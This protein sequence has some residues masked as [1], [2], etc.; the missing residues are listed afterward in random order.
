MCKTAW[1]KKKHC[2]QQSAFFATITPSKVRNCGDHLRC[3]ISSR[4]LVTF[5]NIENTRKQEETIWIKYA[6]CSYFDK[7]SYTYS[8]FFK[9]NVRY[10]VW[11]CRDPIS[12]ILRRRGGHI[13][14]Y[15]VGCMQQP[16]GQMWNV[17]AHIW[18]GGP[19]TTAPHR[20]RRP[21]F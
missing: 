7:I 10:P 6:L 17:G 3:E 12:L 5:Q 18:N 16:G 2:C 8:G 4:A 14:K 9:E 11:T 20:W 19:G 15:C 1:V 21:W 13:L